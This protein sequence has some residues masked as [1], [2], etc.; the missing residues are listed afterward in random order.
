[1]PKIA[2]SESKLVS[3]TIGHLRNL[4]SVGYRTGKSESGLIRLGGAKLGMNSV[5]FADGTTK[6][7]DSASEIGE[8]IQGSFRTTMAFT[9]HP[10][11][12]AWTK[13]T[14][15]SIEEFN[16]QAS[17]YA[18]G[19]IDDVD[20]EIKIVADLIKKQERELA[21]M[22]IKHD[23]AGFT[24]MMLERHAN[25]LPRIFNDERI[26]ELRMRLGADADERIA[27]LVE[28]AIRNA[29]PDIAVDVRKAISKK[30]K[31]VTQADIDG[32]IRKIASGY[33]KSITDP[34]I[35]M[36]K[37]PA[38]ANEMNIEDLTTIMRGQG[39]EADDVD[40]IIEMFTRTGRV[41]GHKRS[42]PRL[43]L[44]EKAS[45]TVT[46]A[47]GTAEEIHFY[48]LLEED[49]EQLHNSYIFQMSGAIGLARNGINTNKV[50]SSFENF[51]EN[52]KKEVKDRNL[53]ADQV[54]KEIN[55]L[56]FMYDG[57][58]GRLAQREDVSNKVREAKP[59]AVRAY[60]FSVNMGMSGMSAL[61]EIS[62]ALFEYS[63]Q[64]LL[65][66]M[67]AYNKLF[68]KASQGRLDDGLMRELVE[69]FGIGGEV[70]LGRYN[71]ATRYEGSNVEGYIGPEQSGWGKRALKLQQIVSYWSG[72]NGVTQTLRRMSMLHFSTQFARALL[73]KGGKVFSDA[74]L[75][76]LGLDNDMVDNIKVAINEHATFKGKIL[77]KLNMDKWPEQVREAFQ[78]AGYKEARQSVQEMNIASTNGFLRSEIGKTF[79]Q[80]LSFPLASLEQQTMRLGT[81]AASGDGASSS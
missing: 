38:G 65:R 13:R 54:A 64:T 29:Q 17:R 12:R 5:G 45:V 76:Q 1:M 23:V 52:I 63:V 49:I 36:A 14:G 55:A 43:I 50:G 16:R 67:P 9:L 2:G 15:G 62:N 60:S 28:R 77:D 27:D 41:K 56:E 53:D 48:D 3:M 66:T 73:K 46:K 10:N 74:K 4:I 44:D 58:T 47:D 70:A 69:G 21:E 42:R 78:A 19:I 33:T 32:Y 6:T 57:I 51:L 30:K 11:Q 71:K 68:K 26:R 72:L 31:K 37:G 7:F 61:M 39:F 75:R 40:N 25:Y 34:K 24:P 80:F 18:R 79:F 81:R 8:R 35:G 20:P 22:G 59:I